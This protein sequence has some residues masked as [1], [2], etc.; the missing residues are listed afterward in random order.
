MKLLVQDFKSTLQIVLAVRV[1]GKAEVTGFSEFREL[2]SRQKVFV[3]VLEL[4][5]AFNPNVTRPK[6]VLELR[7]GA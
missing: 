1:N 7:Q 4:P 6:G 3:E 5:R 2:L